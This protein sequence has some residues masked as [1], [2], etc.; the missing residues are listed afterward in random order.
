MSKM[1]QLHAELSEQAASLG[2][3]TLEQALNDGYVVNYENGKLIENGMGYSD[4]VEYLVNEHQKAHAEWLKEK[5]EVLT[6]L[7]KL[8][9]RLIELGYDGLADDVWHA[10]NFIT[11]G[12][13]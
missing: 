9:D 5:A 7:A 13:V 12:E 10:I 8:Y 4:T 2:Y 3:E 6:E 11:K 1:S